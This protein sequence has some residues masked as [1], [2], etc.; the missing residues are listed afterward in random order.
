MAKRRKSKLDPFA[1]KLGVVPD[2]EL[3]ALAGVSSENVRALRKRRGIPARWRGEGGPAVA[4]VHDARPATRRKVRKPRRAKPARLPA[5]DLPPEPEQVSGLKPGRKPRK[6]KLDPYL[7]KVGV[8]PDK[9]VAELAGVTSENV[10]AYRKRR[11]IPAGWREATKK[12]GKGIA[13]AAKSKKSSAKAPPSTG[14][15]RKP[16]RGKLT[17][18]VDQLGLV[19]DARIAELS[20]TTLGNVRVYRLRHG[21]PARWKLD[22]AAPA[23]AAAARVAPA[24]TAAPR[25]GYQV[26]IVGPDGEVE[27]VVVAKDIVG[28]ASKAVDGVARQGI[29]GRVLQL[30]F[31]GPML[32]G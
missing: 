23:P 8:L 4:P 28:A 25:E 24:A 29:E 16:R 15:V 12:G 10:R 22:K 2:K 18:F 14:K 11:G 26:T 7:D 19:P 31:L 5:D 20:G 1:D 21:I 32:V 6:T 3:A 9:Q 27:Y 13:R 30:R 17:P